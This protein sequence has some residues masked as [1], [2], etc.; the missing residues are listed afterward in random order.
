MPPWWGRDEKGS[1]YRQWSLSV[2][3]GLWEAWS[4]MLHWDEDGIYL[5]THYD[6]PFAC[7]DDPCLHLPTRAHWDMF[8]IGKDD[9]DAWT[10]SS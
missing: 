2:D 4:H 9:L 3:I 5:T 7:R 10:T 8:E 6:P 1:N